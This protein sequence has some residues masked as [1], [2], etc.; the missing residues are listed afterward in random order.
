MALSMAQVVPLK[1]LRLYC[2][3][4]YTH[5]GTHL[6]GA[7]LARFPD[8]ELLHNRRQDGVHR[9]PD[10]R[11]VVH[12]QTPHVVTLSPGFEE[13]LELYRGI[14][15]LPVPG[16]EY[17]VT[18]SELLTVPVEVGLADRL[19]RYQSAT[20]W[21]GL[22]QRNFGRYRAAE[23][24]DERR[25]LLE[26]V[27]VGNL[28]VTLRQM[29]V[30]LTPEQRLMVSVDQW[31]ERTVRVRDQTFLGFYVRVVANLAWS[32]WIGIGKQAAKGFGRFTVCGGAPEGG[33]PCSE[34]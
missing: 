33:E 30:E 15:R 8:R 20:P 18:G 29:G 26:R 5:T 28:L 7:I 34:R 31:R 12:E 1:V 2:E 22:N 32:H 24:S 25:G 3:R 6:R 11:Y 13:A 14:E 16:D 21:L 4:P 17:R 23:S 19:A 10:V 9:L 27:V